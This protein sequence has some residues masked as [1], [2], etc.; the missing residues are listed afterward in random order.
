MSIF[1]DYFFLYKYDKIK[2]ILILYGIF[3]SCGFNSLEMIYLLL[4]WNCKYVN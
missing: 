4:M 1:L 3:L 2:W